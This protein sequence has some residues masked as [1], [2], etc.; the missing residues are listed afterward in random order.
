MPPS[1]AETCDCRRRTM[2]A[3]FGE[4]LDQPC[5][6]CDTCRAGTGEES[7][8]S[9]DDRADAPFPHGS[10]VVHAEWGPGKVV[11]E[12][13]D[14]ITVFFDDQGYKVLD[15]QSVIGRDILRAADPNETYSRV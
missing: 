13:P 15:L 12:E 6:H 1:C 2:L 11:E 9:A 14:R 10:D 4:I 3:Y 7:L 8:R 5:G